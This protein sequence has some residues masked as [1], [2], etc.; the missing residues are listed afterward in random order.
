M[1]ETVIKKNGF[2]LIEISIV[3]IIIGLIIASVVV[4]A[5]MIR[6]AKVSNLVVEI[7]EY[8]TAAAAFQEKYSEYPGDGIEITKSGIGNLSINDAG[9]ND[10]I[11]GDVNST[12]PYL[13]KESYEFFKHLSAAGMIAFVSKAP[14]NGNNLGSLDDIVINE[15]YP[16]TKLGPQYFYYIDSGNLYGLF[17][18]KNKLA[19]FNKEE[20]VKGIKGELMRI[21]NKK[22]EDKTFFSN[23]SEN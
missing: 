13:Q 16:G 7:R 22:F 23:F 14:G 10:G 3:L 12:E 5:S 9:N 4:G 17:E 19:I 20:E 18:S 15:T 21:L 2:S 8:R 1:K 6:V 11:I